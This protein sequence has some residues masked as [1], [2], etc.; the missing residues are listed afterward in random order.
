MEADEEAD[1]EAEV[2]RAVRQLDNLEL[3]PSD[4]AEEADRPA[5]RGDSELSGISDARIDADTETDSD[6]TKDVAPTKQAA[7]KGKVC[8]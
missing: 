2:A 7:A 4:S 3:G 6:T 8:A 1:E 5:S